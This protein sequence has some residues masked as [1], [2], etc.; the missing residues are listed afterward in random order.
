MHYGLF[1]IPIIVVAPLLCALP[2]LAGCEMTFEEMVRA[3]ADDPTY[4]LMGYGLFST[5]VFVMSLVFGR[6]GMWWSIIDGICAAGVLTLALSP[7]YY[8]MTRSFA[9][10]TVVGVTGLLSIVG[11]VIVYRWAKDRPVEDLFRWGKDED[12]K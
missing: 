4:L 6:R 2:F 1:R 11:P 3:S 9:A 8:W 10:G 7:I 12:S 5:I